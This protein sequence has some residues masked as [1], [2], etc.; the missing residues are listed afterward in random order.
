MVATA[1][2]AAASQT[3]RESR[4]ARPTSAGSGRPAVAELRPHLHPVAVDV[5]AAQPQAQGPG[6]RGLAPAGVRAGVRGAV[7][8]PGAQRPGRR[9]AR[10]GRARH[11]ERGGEPGGQPVGDVVGAGGRPAEPR[12]AGRAV[13]DHRVERVHRPVAEQ[14]RAARPPRPRTAGRPRRRRCSRRPT[15]RSRAPARRRPGRWGR[16]RPVT[17]SALRA[18]GRS[19]SSRCRCSARSRPGPATCRPGRSRW[20]RRWRRRGRAGGSRVSRSRRPAGGHRGADQHGGVPGPGRA[21]VAPDPPLE[22]GGRRP[23]AG[24]RVAAAGVGRAQVGRAPR[25]SPAAVG[26]AGG[27]TGSSCARVRHRRRRGPRCGVP[28]IGGHAPARPVRRCRPADRDLRQRPRPAP[29]VRAGDRLRRVAAPAGAGHVR[30]H[31]GRRRRRAGRQPDRRRRAD[32]RHRLPGRRGPRRRRLRGQPGAHAARAGGRR[33]GRGG[34]R[35]G[36]PVGARPLRRA[37]RGPSGPGWTAS[38]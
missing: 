9:A 4:T 30:Q 16:G 32:L 21:G 1:T 18:A 12:V 20:R 22:R 14:A 5:A 36:L 25:A 17:G 33:A 29:A 19:P 6:E 8:P 23:E 11:G 35:G 15:R 31:G 26:R 3:T 24:D 27:V 2:A 13:A 28:R 37:A 34:H 7:P 10:Q 38:T